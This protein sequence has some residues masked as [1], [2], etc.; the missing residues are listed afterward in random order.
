MDIDLNC[1][2]GESFGAYTLGMDDNIIASISSANIACGFH[3][4][5]P[6]VMS[7]TVKLA[8][9]H[10]VAIGAHPGFPDLLGFGRRNMDCSSQELEADL[11]YQIG[12]LQAFCTAHGTRLRHVKPHGALYNMAVGN[13]SLVRSIARAIALVDT[14]LY[15]VT[16]AGG[17]AGRMAAIAR[18]EG[19]TTLY[20]AFPDRTYTPE[21]TLVSR[22]L[23]GAVIHDAEEAADRAVRMAVEGVVLTIDGTVVPI[24]VHTLCV[25]GD[26]PNGVTLAATIRNRLEAAGV[27][28]RPMA[29]PEAR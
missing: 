4:G 13:E 3:A 16:L 1:D 27:R 7:R 29:G 23:P 20:E 28:V 2:M 24:K 15:M 22:R 9:D 14:S 10:K 25:H 18:E 5:D 11:I 26:N 19:I 21:G 6:Q 12:A 8:L 17:N